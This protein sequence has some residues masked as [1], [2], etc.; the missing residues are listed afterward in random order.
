M[1]AGFLF[2]PLGPR[3]N[4]AAFSCGNDS[5]DDFIKTKARKERDLGFCAVFVMREE[6]APS[7]IAGYYTLS[8]HSTRIEGIPEQN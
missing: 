5:L 3:H 4:R 8:T 7:V 2:E 1:P 6:A